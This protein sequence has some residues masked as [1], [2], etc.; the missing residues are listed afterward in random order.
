LIVV[1]AWLFLFTSLC[2]AQDAAKYREYMDAVAK[3][4]KFSGTVLVADVEIT[5]EK[6]RQGSL[7]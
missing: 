3:V 7:C 4:D 5:F 6:D 1:V 2:V